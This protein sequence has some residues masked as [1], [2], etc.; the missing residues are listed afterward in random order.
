M[1]A[2]FV[3]R[4]DV[5]MN[6]GILTTVAKSIY[7]STDLKIREA[8]ANSMDNQADSFIMYYDAPSSKLSLF[9]N[10]IGINEER[11]DRIFQSLG[12]GLYRKDKEFYKYYSYF[13]LGLLSI[14]QLGGK[15]II[16]TKPKE[17]KSLYKIEIQSSDIFKEENSDKHIEDLKNFITMEKTTAKELA[18]VSPL[19]RET[20][21]SC[22]KKK[23]DSFTEIIVE[24]VNNDDK[25]NIDTPSFSVQ[26]SQNLP[27]SPDEKAPFL[28]QIKDDRARKWIK[29][30]LK[31]HAFCPTINFFF[32]KSNQ[33][34]PNQLWK[35]FP[36][37]KRDIT[38]EK[39]DVMYGQS[40]S[41]KF[42]Y[43]LVYATEDLQRTTENNQPQERDTGLWVR[44]RNFLVKSADFLDAPGRK[45]IITDPLRNW[46]Y[47]EIYHENMNEFL[48]VTRKEYDRSSF[49]F[50][51]FRD[52]IAGLIG[53]LNNDLREAW[54]I[55][56]KV[57]KELTQPFEEILSD[58]GP[59]EGLKRRI[60]KVKN[61][62]EDSQEIISALKDLAMIRSQELENAPKISDLI[63]RDKKTILLA[64]SENMIVTIDPQVVNRKTV[65]KWDKDKKR[66][67]LRISPKLFSTQEFRFLGKTFTLKYVAGFTVNSAIS[68]NFETNVI[69]VNPFYPDIKNYSVS[70][71]DFFITVQYAYEKTRTREEM[72][73]YLLNLLGKSISNLPGY[74]DAMALGL[75]RRK[76]QKS[77]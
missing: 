8:V 7:S 61:V 16:F 69:S 9:D 30:Q 21:E 36:N 62:S 11:F 24:G 46:L 73:D 51:E 10:G 13:G 53:N 34:R 63:S 33:K 17:N 72:R 27:L 66:L 68:F 20:V 23:A 75:S 39:T 15:V 32:G 52:E 28:E 25:R 26:L 71:L 31:G 4:P 29:E 64:E 49:D 41:K 67:D 76:V 18:A 5:K 60:A 37:F 77:N 2:E 1:N 35:Y 48:E 58:K 57:E 74:M 38:F 44:N 54:K 47:G 56:D 43:Y 59:F 3:K 55:G 42:I 40:P 6:I 14:L 22:I 45:R 70:F 19:K 50:T 65:R 12:Y